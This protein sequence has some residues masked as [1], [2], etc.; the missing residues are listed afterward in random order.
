M[1]ADPSEGMIFYVNMKD[2]T[3]A[4]YFDGAVKIGSF[5][6]VEYD[7]NVFINDGKYFVSNPLSIVYN[8][9]F[10]EDPNERNPE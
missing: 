2:K 3:I 10:S 8:A 9:R 1:I 6:V 5:I 4:R 7:G